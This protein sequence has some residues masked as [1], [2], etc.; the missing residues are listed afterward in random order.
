MSQED[1]AMED[2]IEAIL[3]SVMKKLPNLDKEH[4]HA[5]SCISDESFASFVGGKCSDAENEKASKHIFNCS[6]CS[7]ALVDYIKIAND[8]EHLLA[9]NY[10]TQPV[11]DYVAENAKEVILD[12]VLEIREKAIELIK[13]TGDI[14]LGP[15]LVPIPVL[16]N[17]KKEITQG[18]NIRVVKKINEMVVDVEIE[19]RRSPSTDLVI[20]LMEDA[21]KKK[22]SGIRIGLTK[23]NREIASFLTQSGKVKFEEVNVGIYQIILLDN[24]KKLGVININ[25][26]PA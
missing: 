23:N 5:E 3:R 12:L 10:I 26:K 18:E 1:F 14:L 9:P 24:D 21:T 19:K 25:L 15:Q 11:L 2:E 8:Q 6:D 22:L 17:A 20:R 13:S 4:E 7:K 16:R